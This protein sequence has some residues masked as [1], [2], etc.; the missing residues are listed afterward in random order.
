MDILLKDLGINNHPNVNL[1]Q[2]RRFNKYS[3]KNNH[4][5]YALLEYGSMPYF[6]NIEG[7]ENKDNDDIATLDA[8]VKS[9]LQQY[10]LAQQDVNND[11][12]EKSKNLG[13]ISKYFGKRID[14][15]NGDQSFYVNQY[16]FKIDIGKADGSGNLG[17]GCPTNDQM[18]GG[19]DPKSRCQHF[20]DYYGA[21]SSGG[22]GYM[23]ITGREFKKGNDVHVGSKTINLLAPSSKKHHSRHHSSH[24]TT[25]H[26]L[27]QASI[28]ITGGLSGAPP[29]YSK[30][31]TNSSVAKDA[32]PTPPTPPT[33]STAPTSTLP[34]APHTSPIE[35]FA[36]G[37]GAPTSP[38]STMPPSTMPPSTM[39]PSTMPPSTMPPSTSNA[40][41][42]RTITVPVSALSPAPSSGPKVSLNVPAP[43]PNPYT[44]NDAK[45]VCNDSSSCRGFSF[46]TSSKPQNN[47]DFKNTVSINATP[48]SDMNSYIKGG[49]WGCIDTHNT[50]A[51]NWWLKNNCSTNP[52]SKI[53][54]HD[55]CNIDLTK[56]QK[57][58]PGTSTKRPCKSGDGQDLAGINIVN[59]SGEKAWLDITGA[60]HP[61]PDNKIIS[62]CQKIPTVQIS[63]DDWDKIPSSTVYA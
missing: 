39:P 59:P 28:N 14:S 2:G 43:L 23:E 58:A 24:H 49:D 61:Y 37:F 19:S 18:Y 8:K 5:N 63:K 20:S 54:T 53:T 35:G 10:I 13:D 17:T 27:Q 45:L 46:P 15:L 33:P 34:P 36:T 12:R 1:N 42:S 4:T 41:G 3:H 55:G 29:P 44:L 60:K 38:P 11:I 9:L 52:D 7:L 6:S 32:S 51:Q 62:A 16:G 21:R 47:V 56:F 22:P 48:V 25:S 40:P 31:G 30:Q 57:G 50:G 26:P